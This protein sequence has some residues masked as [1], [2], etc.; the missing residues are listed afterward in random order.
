[1]ATGGTIVA[2]DP[3]AA[4]EDLNQTYGYES[5]YEK[6]GV[7]PESIQRM[8]QKL[9]DDL[10]ERKAYDIS[11]LAKLPL[12]QLK[13]LYD[14][15]FYYED[16]F[17]EKGGRLGF[18][19]LAKKVAKRYEGKPVK[20]KYQKEYGKTYSKEEALEVGRKVAAKVYGQQQANTN[21]MAKGGEVTFE[22][23]YY[24]FSARVPYMGKTYLVEMGKNWNA[25]FDEVVVSDGFTRIDG[26]GAKN[27]YQAML[28][29]KQN[30]EMPK[31]AKGGRIDSGTKAVEFNSHAGPVRMLIDSDPEYLFING[32]VN[33]K[34]IFNT[35]VNLKTGEV[36]SEKVEQK[37][38][39]N[40]N[41]NWS[42]NEGAMVLDLNTEGVP[43]MAK[44]GS[45]M[46]HGLEV[47]DK[48]V[49]DL[50]SALKVSTK[51]GNIVYV[52][53]ASGYRE[54]DMPLPF[55]KGGEVSGMTIPE[56]AKKFD[57]TT[58]DVF[59]QLQ[60]GEAHEM[61]HTSDPKVARKIALDHLAEDLDYYTKLKKLGL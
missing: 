39:I 23:D 45:L 29:A 5:V 22:N 55:A 37:I 61:E 32:R 17:F 2:A 42:P 15:E 35:A 18:E 25:P 36:E 50:G 44:G 43:Q 38:D 40:P 14:T 47:G 46:G 8:Q 6:G 26:A 4:M 11:Y 59:S 10:S 1:M 28:K 34:Y 20:A 27:I 57:R 12:K 41:Y 54:K 52:D 49:Q 58:A 56:I 60:V 53:L 31:F 13:A 19:G 33:N 51:D 24:G 7:T 16:E 21:K 3:S 30:A 9:I 48:I